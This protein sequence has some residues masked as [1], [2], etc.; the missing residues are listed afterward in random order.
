MINEKVAGLIRN[1][2]GEENI[3]INEP[4]KL[5][6]SFKV[7]GPA[8]ILVKP[9]SA[10]ELAK[11]VDVCNSF[12]MGFYI[13]G[14]GTNLVVRDKGV[15]GVVIKIFENFSGYCVKGD[16]IEAEAGLLLSRI[17]NIALQHN[18]SGFEFASGI[19]GTLGGAVAMNA[20]AYGGEMKDVILATDYMDK[21]GHV[22]TVEGD[23]HEFGYRTSFIQREGGIIL[24]SVIKL[25]KADKSEIEAKITDLTKKRTDKQPLD[26]PSAGS[27]FK[28]PEGHFTGKLIED[29]GLR[30]YRIGDAEVSCKHCGFIVNA[31]DATAAEIIKLIEYIKSEVRGRFGVELQ[32]EVRIIGEE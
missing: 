29:C 6:T 27:V 20:G 32:T 3:K 28:R 19:P 8:D 30:G 2:A 5:H 21:N 24:K 31:G 4:M 25:K 1:I 7:G 10:V 22:H 26:M 17:S 18:L 11:I 16:V 13:M 14:N 23:K 9:A 12:D 15:R